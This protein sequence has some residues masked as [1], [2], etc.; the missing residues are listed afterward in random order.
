M[1]LTFVQLGCIQVT[2]LH[3]EIYYTLVW[4]SLIET[5]GRAT[6]LTHRTSFRKIAMLPIE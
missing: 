1:L 4:K 6:H 5:D 3:K 2:S